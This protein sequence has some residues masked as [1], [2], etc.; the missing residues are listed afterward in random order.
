MDKKMMKKMFSWLLSI[1]MLAGSLHLGAFANLIDSDTPQSEY[2]INYEYDLAEESTE[3]AEEPTDVDEDDAENVTEPSESNEEREPGILVASRRAPEE[4]SPR[5]A[6]IYADSD[7]LYSHRNWSPDVIAT[8]QGAFAPFSSSAFH[9]FGAT[10]SAGEIA[11]QINIESVSVLV[12]GEEQARFRDQV[13]RSHTVEQGA[14]GNWYTTSRDATLMDG[15]AFEIHTLIPA[16]AIGDADYDDFL[17]SLTFTYGELPFE[18]WL[19]GPQFNS[20]DVAT[21]TT[22]G[23]FVH[24]MADDLVYNGNGTYTIESV[25]E[26]RSPYPAANPAAVNIPWEGYRGTNQVGFATAMR[27]VV[28]TFDLSVS[29]DITGVD[30]ELASLPINLNLY[31]DFHLWGEIDQWATDLRAEAGASR[32]INGRHVDVTSLGQSHQGRELWNIVIASSQNAVD[33]YFTYTRPRMTGELDDLLALRSEI[34]A[35]VHHRI[36]I[37]FHNIHPDEVTGVDAQLVMVEELLRQ[38][39]IYF[40]TVRESDTSGITTGP[41]WGTPSPHPNGYVSVA[42]GELNDRNDTETVRI[43]VEEALNYFI[44]IF[45]PTNNPDGHYGMLRGN[46]YGFDLNRDASYQ[47]QIENRLVVE[48][49]LRWNPLAMLEFHGHVGHMLIEPTTGPHNPN[50][51]YDLLNPA[52][53]RAAHIMGRASISGAYYRYLIPA[54]HMTDGWDDGGPMYMPVFLMHFGILGFTLEIPHTNQDSLDANVAMG[55]AFVDHAMDYFEELFLNKLEHNRRG[56]TNADYAELVDPFFTNPFTSPPTQIGRPRQEGL[57]FFP[58]YWVIPVDDFNQWNL[59][60]AYN[61]LE[62]LERHGITIERTTELVEHDG[63]RFPTG[64]YVIDMRQ[65][66][67]GYVNTMLEAGYD[68]SFFTAMYAEITMNFPDLRGFDAIAVW[69]ED[70]FDGAS[71]IVSSVSSLATVVAPGTSNYVTIRNNNQDAI[72]LVNALFRE[73]AD[74]WMMTSYLPEGVVGDFIVERSA[75]TASVLD[76]LFV[77]TTALEVRPQSADELEQPRIAFLGA[78]PGPTQ[79]LHTTG[80]YILRDLGFEYVW[81]TQNAACPEPPVNV[82][83]SHLRPCLSLLDLTPGVDFNIMVNHNVNWDNLAVISNE[84]GIP[85]VGVQFQASVNEL[86]LERGLAWDSIPASRE[87]TFD[88]SFSLSS[89]ITGHYERVDGAYLIGTTTFSSIPESATP[90]IRIDSG[91]FSDVFRGG[92][93]AGDANQENVP[94]RVTAFTG[95]TNAGV[96]ATVFGTNIFNRSH[97]QVYH[98]LFGTAV[99]MHV[100]DVED[101]ARPFVIATT[102][103]AAGELLVELDFIASEREGSEA[104]IE[105]QMFKVSNNPTASAFN[106]ETAADDGW[107]VYTEPF[108]IDPAT[109]FVHW[110][111]VNS[112]GVSAQGNFNFGVLTPDVPV[113]AV[114]VTFD[115]TGG[116]VTPEI[117]EVGEDGTLAELPIPTR[118]G[119]RFLGWFTA[120]DNGEEVTTSTVFVTDTTVF[121]R[122]EIDGIECPEY[123]EC[124][125]LPSTPP[126]PSTPGRPSLPETG[127][128][129]GSALLVG[130]AIATAGVV[131]AAKKKNDQ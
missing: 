64:T 122:W 50:Y 116:V 67:R 45:V 29:S 4:R 46:A 23:R 1:L 44:F 104:T 89:A 27:H 63:M 81:V 128:V 125:T 112:Y 47:T 100:S 19:G 61:M 33:D 124:P 22:G 68:A 12:A 113:E 56:M 65:A 106:A 62:K 90:L 51:E 21:L 109:E 80:P 92:W 3:S 127:A 32:T 49:V 26:F 6:T 77:E 101:H 41:I 72:R 73:G 9:L 42:R 66:R 24:W 31:D 111:A 85:V 53:L 39:Y 40:E 84:Y 98:N 93:W 25:I 5:T 18:A 55:W 120:V 105:T 13:G 35:G 110:F 78:P 34:E 2:A 118:T 131:A 36:P 54:E 96:P 82:V 48:D 7:G 57:S 79:G 95:E 69:E 126:A 108:V 10:R 74:V 99:L 86:F 38:D 43:S 129:V 115:P 107:L 117:M 17:D 130:L 70:L 60:E 88:A 97:S 14:S 94:G 119:Y 76:E 20:S 16:A 123:P 83:P 30:V 114:T 103:D 121:A 71:E 102:T 59:L 52:M 15:R 28:G 75:L 87:G 58:D 91:D 8:F 11:G 37:Y